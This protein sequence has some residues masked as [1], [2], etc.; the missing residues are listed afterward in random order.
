MG[1]Q[2]HTDIEFRTPVIKSRSTTSS[3]FNKE[4]F[5]AA[6]DKAKNYIE[7]GIFFKL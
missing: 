4:S 1:N 3:N 6:V 7:K 5:I 2:L